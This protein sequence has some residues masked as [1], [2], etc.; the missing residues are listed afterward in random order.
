MKIL[1]LGANGGLGQT[2]IKYGTKK[3]P[4]WQWVGLGRD[5]LDLTRTSA[6]KKVLKEEKADVVINASGFT[7]VD[8]AE[9]DVSLAFA[10]NDRAVGLMAETCHALR[11]PFVTFSTVYVEEAKATLKC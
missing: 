10:V 7:S 3:L 6:V 4:D 9:K 11:C 2:F 5:D 8:Q 1:V